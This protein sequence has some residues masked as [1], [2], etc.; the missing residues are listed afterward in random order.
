MVENRD[1]I[2]L[3]DEQMDR[4]NRLADEKGS[5]RFLDPREYLGFNIFDEEHDEPVESGD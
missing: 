2:M 1:L 5:V 3:T 4:I